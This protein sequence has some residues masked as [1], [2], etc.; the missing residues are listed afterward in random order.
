[1][2]EMED[3]SCAWVWTSAVL[4]SFSYSIFQAVQSYLKIRGRVAKCQLYFTNAPVSQ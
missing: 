1:M 4:V 2:E 3:F